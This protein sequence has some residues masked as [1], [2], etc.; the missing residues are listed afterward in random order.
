MASSMLKQHVPRQRMDLNASA[1]RSAGGILPVCGEGELV[2]GVH[3]P[4]LYSFRFP[5]GDEHAIGRAS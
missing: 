4:D 2:H 5:H 1:H 3:G